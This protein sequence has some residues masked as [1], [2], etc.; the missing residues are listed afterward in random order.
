MPKQFVTIAAQDLGCVPAT[1]KYKVNKLSGGLIKSL[2]KLTLRAQHG[3]SNNIE[4][5][6]SR[7][8]SVSETISVKSS[9]SASSASVVATSTA[10]ST[11]AGSIFKGCSQ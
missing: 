1:F 8:T 5:I 7:L 11:S 2:S 6:S 10:P 4:M 3:I 9:G